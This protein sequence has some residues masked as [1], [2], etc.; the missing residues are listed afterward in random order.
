MES[1]NTMTTTSMR[2]MEQTVG[3]KGFIKIPSQPIA[4]IVS[5]IICGGHEWVATGREAEVPFL[6]FWTKTQCQ[7]RCAKCG[8]VIWRDK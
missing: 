6:I 4:D 7:F 8:R 2:E 5:S 3:G 1:S